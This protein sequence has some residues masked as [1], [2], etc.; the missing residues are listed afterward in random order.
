MPASR[1]SA[2]KIATM[3]ATLPVSIWNAVKISIASSRPQMAPGSSEA[4]AL[5]FH[6]RR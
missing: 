4:L 3:T 6:A 5:R 2:T 1:I